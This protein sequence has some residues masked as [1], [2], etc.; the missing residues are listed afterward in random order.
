[1]RFVFAAVLIGA[2]SA[3]ASAQS[4]PL[5]TFVQKGNALKRKG[6]LA[7]LSGDLKLLQNEM[8]GAG[9]ALR[10]ERLAAIKAGK[11]PA[12][13][14]PE[15]GVSMDAGEVLASLNAIPAAQR[16][17]MTSKDGFRQYMARRFPCRG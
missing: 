9:D 6:P 16:A 14:P 5:E 3:P 17:R 12:Y 4:M 7:L 13:C 1:M 2:C 11:K 8:R 10:S 15:S